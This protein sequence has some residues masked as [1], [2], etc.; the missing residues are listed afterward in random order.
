[1][2]VKIESAVVVKVMSPPP[3][4]AVV[5][6]LVRTP[7]LVLLTSEVLTLEEATTVA[8]AL[9]ERQLHLPER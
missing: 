7:A 8:D 3:K 1:M 6:L 4:N 2:E 5:S 9:N